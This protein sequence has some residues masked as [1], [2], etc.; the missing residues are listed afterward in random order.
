MTDYTMAGIRGRMLELLGTFLT[1]PRVAVTD[2]MHHTL[3]MVPNVSGTH[4]TCPGF[5]WN[6]FFWLSFCYD[7]FLF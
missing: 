4:A 2:D 1:I 6:V 5:Y 3:G 7:N